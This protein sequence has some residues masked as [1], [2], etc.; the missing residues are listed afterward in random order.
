MPTYDYRCNECGYTFDEFQSMKAEPLRTCPECKKD[1]LKRLFGAGAGLIFKGSGFYITDYKN[2]GNGNRKSKDSVG[3][4]E[5]STT[6]KS[7]DKETS[8]KSSATT[9]R[10]EST[11]SK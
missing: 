7:S 10:K 6:K 1:S 3:N 11:S 8:P 2:N 5:E 9:E 4:N